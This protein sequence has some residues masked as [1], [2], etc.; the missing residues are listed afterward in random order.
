MLHTIPA[1]VNDPG[2]L[3][4]RNLLV[5]LNSCVPFRKSPIL[6]NYS[7]P[8]CFVSTISIFS[9]CRVSSRPACWLLVSRC[10]P[11]EFGGHCILTYLFSAINPTAD[12]HLRVVWLTCLRCWHERH[13]DGSPFAVVATRTTSGPQVVR[14]EI[15]RVAYSR[16][17]QT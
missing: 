6:C 12:S 4:E 10:S 5:A 3:A 11:F 9:D 17:R 13:L 2:Q 15:K 14:S 8:Q 7:G 1:L 16:K